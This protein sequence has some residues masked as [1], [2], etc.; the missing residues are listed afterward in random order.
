MTKELTA[1]KERCVLHTN[2]ATNVFGLTVVLEWA[3]LVGNAGIDGLH[4]RAI[5]LPGRAPFKADE[6]DLAVLKNLVSCRE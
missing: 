6:A 5:G 4:P 3:C 1:L 2:T